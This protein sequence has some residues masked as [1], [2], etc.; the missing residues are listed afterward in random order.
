MDDRGSVGILFLAII[1]FVGAGLAGISIYVGAALGYG[2][3]S[4]QEQSVRVSLYAAARETMDRLAR[5]A[6]PESDG[7]RDAVWSSLG[8]RDDGIRVSLSDLS[9]RL[10]PNFASVELLEKTDFRSLFSPSSS[11]EYL[12]S[13]RS[14]KGMSTELGHYSG[15]FRDDAL[16]YLSCFGWANVNTADRASLRALYRSLTG[17][18]DGADGFSLQIDA[19]RTAKRLITPETLRSFLGSAYSALYPMICAEAPYN[20]NL[21]SPVVIKAILSYLPF[22]ISDPGGRAGAIVAARED[23]DLT[24]KEIASLCGTTTSQQVLQYLGVRTWF[25]MIRAEGSGHAYSAVVAASPTAKS[26]ATESRRYTVVET[27]F[28]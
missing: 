16:Q 12:E 19:T 24:A 5:D 3:R 18:E 25:W 21:A 13:Y 4:E 15:I 27:R 20:A 28:E 2:R 23:H 9:S 22:G 6:T 8:P 10:N 1:L 17:S 7:P 11:P 14:E 26:A